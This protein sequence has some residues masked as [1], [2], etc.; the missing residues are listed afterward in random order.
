[1]ATKK[2]DKKP[3]AKRASAP[4]TRAVAAWRA[5]DAMLADLKPHPKNYR[6][7][8]PAQLEHIKSSLEQHGVYRN[9]V[10]ARDNTISIPGRWAQIPPGPHRRS[11][12]GAAVEV[13]ELLD[14]RLLVRLE[15]DRTVVLSREID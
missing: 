14:G 15:I 9:V 4:P 8:P 5:D 13:R 2:K 1:M 7:H 11:W 3:A 12:Q 6:S 10:V